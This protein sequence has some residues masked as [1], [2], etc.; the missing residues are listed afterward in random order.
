MPQRLSLWRRE[1]TPTLLL[2]GPLV[3]AQLLQVG[4]GFVD[5]VMAGRLGASALAA[6]GLGSSL[7]GLM[8]LACIGATLAISPLVAHLNGAGNDRAIAAEFHQGLWVAVLVGV[9]AVPLT[10]GMAAA[11]PLLAI[12]PE[13]APLAADYLRISAW[14]MPGLCL[15]LAPRYLN[16]G[17][18]NTKPVML[19]QALLLPLNILGN[20]LFMYGFMFGGFGFPAMGAAGAALSTAIGLWLGALMMFGYLARS[21]R[22]RH[23]E[24]FVAFSGPR[25]KEI[26]RILRLGLPIAVSIIMEVG[27]FSAVAILMGRLGKVEMAAHQIALNY[28]AMMFMLPLSIAQAITIRVGHAAGAGDYA[29]ALIR[30]RVGIVMAG[31]IMA[32]SATLLLLFP[33]LIVAL[34]TRDAAVAEM[35]MTLLFAAALFQFSDGLQVSASGALRGLKDTAVPMFITMFSYWGVGF[36]TAWII[37]VEWGIGPQGL[38]GGLAVGLTTAALLLNLRFYLLGRKRVMLE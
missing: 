35:A 21:R 33:E 28:A 16:E 14:G 5:T 25:P 6:V 4:M 38:W 24:L 11:L 2:A 15:Y 12:D 10:Y 29:L 8:L 27:M 22:F 13:V 19:V 36:P 23:L 30:G 31:G 37:G 18:S 17:L 34:Y 20:Y 3:V 32:L 9:V 1:A 7:W 26:E